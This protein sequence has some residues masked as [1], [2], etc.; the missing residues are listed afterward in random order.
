M[1]MEIMDFVNIIIIAFAMIIACIKLSCV[2][3]TKSE[4]INVYGVKKDSGKDNTYNKMCILLVCAVVLV[5][6]INIIYSFAYAVSYYNMF[7]DKE[8]MEQVY[9]HGTVEDTGGLKDGFMRLYQEL[10]NE[11]I[12]DY[13]QGNPHDSNNWTSHF[14]GEEYIK[15]E[16]FDSYPY[17][18]GFDFQKLIYTFYLPII[19]GLIF[20]LYMF[21]SKV[22]R[23]K[24]HEQTKAIIWLNFLF[25]LTVVGWIAMLIWANSEK[26]H[27]T[28]KVTT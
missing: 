13:L 8:F 4:N 23:K 9:L 10:Q 22:A 18:N 5:L 20:F 14:I 27:K 6:I 19:L 16:A 28:Y 17:R 24:A 7:H 3:A 15:E 26:N 2:V 11:S 25:G 21:P 1:E 12:T